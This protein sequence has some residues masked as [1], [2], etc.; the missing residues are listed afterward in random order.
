EIRTPMNAVI[1]LGQLLLDTE[2]NSTQRE[3]LDTLQIASKSLLGILNAILDYSK[4]EAGCMEL[5]LADF[6]L[7]EVLENTAKLFARSAAEHGVALVT[8]RSPGVPDLVRGDSVRLAQI[9]NNLVG[10]AVKFTDEGEIHVSVEMGEQNNSGVALNFSVSDTGIGIDPGQIEALFQPFTQADGSITRTHGGTGLGLAICA[11]LVEMMGGELSVESEPGTGSVFHFTVH[12]SRALKE[13][14][15]Q[16]NRRLK[17][18]RTLAVDDNRMALENLENILRGWDFVV[19]TASSAEQALK[20]LKQA[21]DRGQPIE[22]LLVDWR[23]P[24]MNGIELIRRVREWT[25][26]GQI[27]APGRV[28]MLAD[29]SRNR[30]SQFAGG[31]RPDAIMEKPITAFRVF[32]TLLALQQRAPFQPAS[33]HSRIAELF[34]L[35]RP[36]HGARILLVEDN[37]TNQLVAKQ[38]LAKLGVQVQVAHHGREAVHKVNLGD[39]DLIFMD[40]QMPVMDGFEATRAIRETAKGRDMPII[41]MTAAAML[42]DR[43][44]SEAAGMNAHLAKPFELSQLAEILLEWIPPLVDRKSPMIAAA[45]DSMPERP[46]QP[47][48]LAGLDLG[49]AVARMDG[50]W[51]LMRTVLRSFHNDFNDAS[52]RLGD[53]LSTGDYVAARCLVHTIKGLSNSI[54]AVELGAVSSELEVELDRRNSASKPRFDR[55]LAAVMAAVGSLDRRRGGVSSETDTNALQIQMTE[56][57]AYL[58]S[59]VI[60]P[61]AQR[62]RIRN[63]LDGKVD[64]ELIEKLLDQIGQL[65]YAEALI[66]LREVCR[67]LEPDMT[68]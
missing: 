26:H 39:F 51:E 49:T 8:E 9:L 55:V 68:C 4:I 42:K 22:L 31:T 66:S 62:E 57:K 54:G 60:V 64:D 5:E 56:L 17:A 38:L 44:A 50:D 28:V 32:E 1:G 21:S 63:S 13:I 65:R 6:S 2:L 59:A 52:S 3:Y 46:S 24:E 33:E 19:T 41:A 35:T 48:E 16:T 58:E 40:L 47:F 43:E 11:S 18:M 29:H 10:N 30:P 23:M 27:V 67:R 14:D 20:M 15:L 25:E 7:D 37:L 12:L 36:V 53:A 61:L 34:E 45:P